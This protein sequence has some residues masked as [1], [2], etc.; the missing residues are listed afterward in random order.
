MYETRHF[1]R[2]AS[3]RG[4]RRDV[5][6]FILAWGSEYQLHGRRYLTLR[7]SGVPRSL[8][9][10]R[11]LARS[12]NWIVVFDGSVAITCYRAPGAVHHLERRGGQTADGG[13]GNV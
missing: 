6:E 9:R 11:L 7:W 10:S 13:R 5:L 3:Q 4:L 12:L 8:R 1:A 2:R